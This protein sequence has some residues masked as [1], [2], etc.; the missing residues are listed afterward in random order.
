MSDRVLL[1][2]GQLRRNQRDDQRRAGGGRDGRCLNEHRHQVRRQRVERRDEHLLGRSSFQGADVSAALRAQ[3][4]TKG[5]P[6][7]HIYDFNANIGGPLKRD[8]AWFFSLFRRFDISTQVLGI[9]RPDGSPAPDLN[10]QSNF[11]GKVTAQVN[12]KNKIGWRVQ[13]QL[14]EPL[15][16]AAHER[17][18]RGKS[19]M[20]PD[21]AGLH[22]A[23]QWT[24]LL[25]S[26]LFLDARYG[27]LHLIF[28]LHYQPEVGA[29]DFARQESSATRSVAQRRTT[30]STS[31][32][33]IRRMSPR[34]TSSTRTT[35]RPGFDN[36]RAFN[37]NQYD[38][39]GNEVLRYLD[40]APLEVRPTTRRSRDRTTSTRSCCTRRIHG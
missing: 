34:L 40:G 8:K 24:S 2:P 39:N 20:A 35:S 36:G 10:H 32:R 26:K 18:R 28:P 3:G 33:G 23:I 38:A 5:N 25:T 31:R 15:L 30:T 12:D 17:P 29:N 27:F 22:L 1:R 19:L 16:P 11:V 21:R 4:V 14:P 9:T 37:Q 6:I 7:N 13:L